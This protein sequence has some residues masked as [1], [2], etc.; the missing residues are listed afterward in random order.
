MIRL[1]FIYVIVI[2]MQLRQI[3]SVESV[4]VSINMT[5]YSLLKIK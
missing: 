4:I 5:S 3:I 2:L 1:D